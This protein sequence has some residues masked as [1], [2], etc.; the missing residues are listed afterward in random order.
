MTIHLD[1][2]TF[3]SS[4]NQSRY[5]V[6]SSPPVSRRI[7]HLKKK[8][9]HLK[10]QGAWLNMFKLLAWRL[11]LWKFWALIIQSDWQLRNN[12]NL[13]NRPA[14]RFQSCRGPQPQKGIFHPSM[15]LS[16]AISPMQNYIYLCLLFSFYFVVTPPLQR[17]TCDSKLR[18][19]PVLIT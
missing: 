1:H 2:C 8:T 9:G 3:Y 17:M 10:K 4:T 7:G 5:Y 13:G 14:L 12:Q 15:Q 16:Q 19:F 18:I 11:A 6:F